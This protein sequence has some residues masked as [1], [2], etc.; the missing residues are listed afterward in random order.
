[1]VTPEEEV[2]EVSP[3]EFLQMIAGGK[4]AERPLGGARLVV[5]GSLDLSN[6]TV[7]R[8]VE[9]I[10]E[11]E[12]R[13]DLF[14]VGCDNLKSARCLVTGS[15]L[16]D[17]T[18]ISFL[19]GGFRTGKGLSA[20]GCKELHSVSGRVGGDA[21]FRGG[22]LV[23]LEGDFSCE[24]DLTVADCPDL[25]TLDCEVGGSVLADG[26][27]LSELG[28]S[29]SCGGNLTLNKC[30]NF[31]EIGRLRKPP[32]VVYLGRSGIRA[33][34]SGFSCRGDLVLDDVPLLEHLGG[35]TAGRIHVSDAPKLLTIDSVNAG[36]GLS[37]RRCPRLKKASFAGQGLAFFGDCGMTEMPAP[38]GWK[39][40]VALSGCGGITKFGGNW[41]GGVRLHDLYSLTELDADF[42]CEG[43]LE[44]HCCPEL[45]HLRGKVGGD[46]FVQEC[47][48]LVVLGPELSVGGRLI[49]VDGDAPL[50]SI[51]CSVS[52][53]V[54]LSRM[55]HLEETAASF[56]TDGELSVTDCPSFR[57][58]RGTVGGNATISDCGAVGAIGADFECGR[59]LLVK[60]CRPLK[61]VNCRV[62][63]NA[64]FEESGEPAIGP[65]FQCGGK[66]RLKNSSVDK[67]TDGGIGGDRS[68]DSPPPLRKPGGGG[69]GGGGRGR[70]SQFSP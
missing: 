33:V 8:G 48:K 35:S 18:G 6:S 47:R 46:A 67:K 53:N 49:V 10:P 37:V 42:R 3:E 45:S 22:G 39:G 63:N 36:R 51:G 52:G 17:K 9:N 59:D 38:A 44:L 14:A 54:V 13:G 32:D 43:G 2:V 70:G 55:K 21:S 50:R 41:P 61:V 60:R 34:R 57:S 56:R 31:H 15:A 29:F 7:G 19:G 23:R 26:S 27:A 12:I 62:G 68:E 64:R 25:Q 4:P 20:A 11:C 24:G 1:M 28:S 69:V 65:A 40:D 5:T 16:L 66:L 30:A 58:L